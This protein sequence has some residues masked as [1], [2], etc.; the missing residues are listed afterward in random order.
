MV[1]IVDFNSLIFIILLVAN[2]I[3]CIK[4]VPILGL[5]LGFLTIVLTGAVFMGD[6]LIN[7]YFSYVLII[8]SFTCMLINGLD[9]K[10][11]K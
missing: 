8:I 11:K 5:A 6:I 10:K 1:A 2:I 7:I 4:T 3:L 9:T